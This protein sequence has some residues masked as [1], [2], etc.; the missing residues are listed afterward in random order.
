MHSN[1]RINLHKWLFLFMT[2]LMIAK[3]SPAKD[4]DGSWVAIVIINFLAFNK[5]HI[6]TNL[7]FS[8]RPHVFALFSTTVCPYFPPGEYIDQLSFVFVICLI[9]QPI[10]KLWFEPNKPDSQG[11]YLRGQGCFCIINLLRYYYW[12]SRGFQ[13]RTEVSL[14][15]HFCQLALD[16]WTKPKS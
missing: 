9:L 13:L 1:L 6:Y 2:K 7:P 14:C 10:W 12:D 8:M 15:K 3:T 11:P 4:T 5:T 16:I